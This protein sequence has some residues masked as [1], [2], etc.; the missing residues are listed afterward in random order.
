MNRLLTLGAAMALF[1]FLSLSVPGCTASPRRPP[2]T[3]AP[4]AAQPETSAGAIDQSDN[5][6]EFELRVIRSARGR[7]ISVNRELR[8]VVIDFSL[9]ASP[10]ENDKLDVIRDGVRV[11]SVRVNRFARH[12][13]RSADIVEGTAR[14]G[15]L[16]LA[17]EKP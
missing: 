7:V 16:V 10:S 14:A 4:A 11:G 6:S 15:D 12:S 5:D 17:P 8:F 9:A 13:Y 1:L 2:G 3:G